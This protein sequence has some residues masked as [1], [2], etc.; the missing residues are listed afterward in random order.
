MQKLL[1]VLLAAPALSFASS[2]NM[3][4]LSCKSVK[5]NASTT[6]AEVQANC[7]IRKQK[8]K[9]GLYEVKFRNDTTKKNVTCLFPD[10][11]PKSPLNSCE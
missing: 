9:D 5:L 8:A 3:A 10:N 4:T 6:L 11:N 1:L 7:L 2:L